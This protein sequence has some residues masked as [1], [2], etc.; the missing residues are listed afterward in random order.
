MG[1][2][3]GIKI[4]LL[5]DGRIVDANRRHETG[6]LI[7]VTRPERLEQKRKG[8]RFTPHSAELTLDTSIRIW[9]GDCR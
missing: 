7:V 5:F 1:A 4:D 3:Q 9:Y 8:E 6:L 2:G